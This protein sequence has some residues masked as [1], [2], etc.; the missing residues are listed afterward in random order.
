MCGRVNPKQKIFSFGVISR[1]R[2]EFGSGSL[3]PN[4]TSLRKK[5]S[6]RVYRQMNVALPGGIL[7]RHTPASCPARQMPH[8]TDE[9][10][11]E[12]GPIRNKLS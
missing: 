11:P 8:S 4:R 9:A 1:F 7:S 12:Q 5:C 6:D 3:Q 2:R 10:A